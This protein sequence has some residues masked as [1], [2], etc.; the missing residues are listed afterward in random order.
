MRQEEGKGPGK[1]ML[2]GPG[3]WGTTMPSLGIPVKFAEV[4]RACV[5]CEIVAM[6]EGLVPDVSLGTHFFNELVENDV[7]YMALFP[8]AEGNSLNEDF[9]RNAPNRFKELLPGE[10]ALS[11][12]VRVIDMAQIPGEPLLRLNADTPAQKVMCHLERQ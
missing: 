1:V 3:R 6:R 11:D 2:V 10:D 8:G 9:F 7:L 4:N 5:L 12:A